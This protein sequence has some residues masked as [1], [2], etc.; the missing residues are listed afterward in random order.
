MKTRR[1]RWT[2]STRF[3]VEGLMAYL[4]P[5]HRKQ[6]RGSISEVS[7]KNQFLPSI[8]TGCQRENHIIR[9]LLTILKAPTMQRNILSSKGAGKSCTYLS[10]STCPSA[11]KGQQVTNRP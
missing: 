6:A 10:G 4:F 1:K 2:L 11:K 9:L 5:C 3:S 7:M 8:S